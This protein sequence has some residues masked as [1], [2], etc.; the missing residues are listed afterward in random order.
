VVAVVDITLS[1]SRHL[2][3]LI[4]LQQ[5]VSQPCFVCGGE[6]VDYLRFREHQAQMLH[7][8]AE[9]VDRDPFLEPRAC[10]ESRVHRPVVPQ[11]LQ[12]FSHAAQQ[13]EERLQLVVLR[14]LAVDG[15]R[16]LPVRHSALSAL[17]GCRAR[18]IEVLC[19]KAAPL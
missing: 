5:L 7:R 1:V 4:H 17:Q 13:P 2:H 15:P 9:V 19:R 16:N 14:G 18:G 12:V 6:H 3:E 8:A 11:P 10:G